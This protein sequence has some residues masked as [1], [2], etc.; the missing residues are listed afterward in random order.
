[1]RDVARRLDRALGSAVVELTPLSGGDIASVARATLADGRKVIVKQGGPCATEARM[2]AAIGASGCPVPEVFHAD[3]TI[4]VMSDL[5]EGAGS[6]AA[7]AEAGEAIACLHATTGETYGWS[8]DTSF[9]PA[10]CPAWPCDEWPTYWIERRLLA[11]PEALPAAVANRVQDL[12]AR[13]PDLVERRPRPSLLHGDLW[14]GNVLLDGDRFC[15]LIDPACY[16]GDAEVDLALL[17]LFGTPPESFWAH[18]GALAPGWDRRRALYQLW[19]ALVHLRLFGAGYRSMVE[20][21]LD[22]LGV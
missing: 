14:R 22:A 7:W 3:D 2:L 20:A 15:G 13:V 8:E 9:G 6:D 11:W 4:L 5:G 19:P 10:P 21:R 17:T 16:H 12:A 18:Y 1:M